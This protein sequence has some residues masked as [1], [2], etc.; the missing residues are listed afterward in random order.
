MGEKYY[1]YRFIDTDGNILYIGRTNDIE[2]RISKEHFTELGHLPEKCYKSIAKIEYIEIIN[3][4]EEVAYEAI[5]INKFRPKYNI[6]F[7]DDGSFNIELPEFHWETFEIDETYLKYLKSRKDKTVAF[8]DF[9]LG[10]FSDID[11]ALDGNNIKT[12]FA[13]IDALT[14]ISEGDLILV[15]SEEGVGKTTFAINVALHLAKDKKKKVLY[16]NLKDSGEEISSRIVSNLSG[17][18]SYRIKKCLLSD[19]DWVKISQSLIDGDKLS[20]TLGNLSYEEKTIDQI[21]EIIRKDIF[22]FIV[23]DGL[24]S[25]HSKEPIYDKDKMKDIMDKLNGLALDIRTPIMVLCQLSGKKIRSR[26][27]NRP[28]KTDLEFD[29]LRIYPNIIFLL[30][31]DEYYNDE[32]DKKNIIELIIEKNKLGSTGKVEL[33]TIKGCSKYLCIVKD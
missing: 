30:Y 25:I 20:I 2:R 32:T 16:L 3:E 24:E 7:K 8:G 33:V 9:L 22:D 10:L 26:I 19:D 27:D 4:S 6:Q 15:A 5:L 18:P 14:S 29:S 1:I 13:E 31:S 23:I 21:I 12:G 11:L 17:I 28:N